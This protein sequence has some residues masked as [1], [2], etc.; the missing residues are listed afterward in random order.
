[1]KLHSAA[2]FLGSL[3][4]ATPTVTFIANRINSDISNVYTSW[5]LIPCCEVISPAKKL[6]GPMT[7]IATA[8]KAY[9][10]DDQVDLYQPISQE[11]FIPS[12]TLT[13]TGELNMLNDNPNLTNA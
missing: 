5:Q 3:A 7:G 1:M 2:F 12:F 6:T 13:L 11:A 8:L 4:C 9:R 10:S